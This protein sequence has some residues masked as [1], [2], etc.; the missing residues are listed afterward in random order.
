MSAQSRKPVPF[1]IGFLLL[2]ATFYF[3]SYFLR[4][5]C[6]TV[7]STLCFQAYVIC[8]FRLFI[9]LGGVSLYR[10][11]IIG[12][13]SVRPICPTVSGQAPSIHWLTEIRL[14][15]MS[16]GLCFWRY[17]HF[18]K[19]VNGKIFLYLFRIVLWSLKISPATAIKES[20]SSQQAP[21]AEM[22]LHSNQSLPPQIKRLCGTCGHPGNHEFVNPAA[23]K[24]WN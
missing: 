11:Q 4:Y 23:C 19:A 12:Q 9:R 22:Y 15:T 16:A 5:I 3:Q 17:I 18:F 6:Q 13:L 10:V 21:L 14:R 24:H 1:G 2:H 20:E 7:K 8:R